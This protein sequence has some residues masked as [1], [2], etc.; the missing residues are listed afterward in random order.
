MTTTR[1]PED[2]IEIPDSLRDM[3]MT[4]PTPADQLGVHP[5]PEGYCSIHGKVGWARM[6]LYDHD[7][8]TFTE[9]N[10]VSEHCVYCL[11]RVFVALVGVLKYDPAPVQCTPESVKKQGG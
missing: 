7:P 8:T 11:S 4:D 2:Q 3:I 10:V 5:V 1:K 9:P 6:V